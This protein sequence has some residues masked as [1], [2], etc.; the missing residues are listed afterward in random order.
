[1]AGAYRAAS[2][3]MIGSPRY[4]ERIASGSPPWTW[5][6]RAHR[7]PWLETCWQAVE[8]L[9]EGPEKHRNDLKGLSPTPH[10]GFTRYVSRSR[11]K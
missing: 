1:M 8:C 6:S 7:E 4:R 5:R 2:R 9:T 3:R 10:H 11:R